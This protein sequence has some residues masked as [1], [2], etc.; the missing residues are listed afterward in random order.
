[1]GRKP[2]GKREQLVDSI[3]QPKKE[4]YGK[5]KGQKIKGKKCFWVEKEITS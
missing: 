5:K 2:K 1:V 4:W 3:L